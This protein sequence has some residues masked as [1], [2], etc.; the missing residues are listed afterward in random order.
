MLDSTCFVPC[1]VIQMCN[2]NQ[3]MHTF[4]MNV[5]IQFLN[6]IKTFIWKCAFVGLS[7]IVLDS[8]AWR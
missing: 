4:Q 5:L 3:Q 2:V 8:F 6:W 7:Y 1:T